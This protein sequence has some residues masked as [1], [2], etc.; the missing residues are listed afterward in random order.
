MDGLF[1]LKLLISFV[2]GS[3]WVIGATIAADKYGSKIGG[4]VSGLPSTALFSLFFIAWTQNP[5]AA[6]S[7]TTIIPAVGGVNCMYLLVYI[8]LVKRNV[9]IALLSSLITW[10]GFSLILIITHFN[11]FVISV[12]MYIV[13]RLYSFYIIEN[14]LHVI[15]VS[16]KKIAYTPQMILSRGIVSGF[17]IVTSVFASRVGGP[18]LGGI[19]AMFPA[20]FT[21]TMMITYFAHGPDFSA[22]TMKSSL[23]GAIS[24]VIYALTVRYTYT[25]VGIFWGTIISIAVSYLVGYFLY[26]R[27]IKKLE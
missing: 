11:N 5:Q 19:F 10:F 1:F 13:L 15:S 26:K 16:G 20:M 22:A 4:L 23:V 21:S 17:I 6:V 14:R 18:L 3:L 27:I 2:V 24:V 9:W 12:G 25:N 7:A 8:L